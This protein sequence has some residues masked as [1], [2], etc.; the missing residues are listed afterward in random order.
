M[1]LQDFTTQPVSVSAVS[2]YQPNYSKP[3]ENQYVFAYRIRIT[4][5]GKIPTRLLRRHWIVTDAAGEIRE[6]EGEGVVGKQPLILPGDTHEYVSW[7]QL[8]T[9]LGAMEGSYLMERQLETGEVK[10]FNATVPRF[11]HIAPELNN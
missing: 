10:H 1:S 3:L 11:L 5:H 7:I 2:I 8:S 9:P 4:N 6:V